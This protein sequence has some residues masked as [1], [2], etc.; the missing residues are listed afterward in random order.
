MAA[1]CCLA[2]LLAGC[3]HDQAGFYVNQSGEASADGGDPEGA[4]D[5]AQDSA[6]ERADDKADGESEEGRES[7]DRQEAGQEMI[8]VQISGAVMHPGVYQ[9]AAGSRIFEAVELAGGPSEEADLNSV[10]QAEAL[11]D[12]QMVYLYA[13]GE[14]PK[15]DGAQKAG[16]AQEAEDGLVNLN[17]ASVEQ[18]MTLPGIGQSKADSIISWREKNGGFGSVEDIMKIEG[19]KEGVFSKIKDH[20]KVD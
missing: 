1:I 20:I 6:L 15:N 2:L 13:V 14:E 8:Y 5:Q 16:E 17:T 11:R 19:I 3:G 9:L 18:L 4:A 10:N 7:P 12:G